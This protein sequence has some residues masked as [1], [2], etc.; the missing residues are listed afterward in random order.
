[1]DLG[2]STQRPQQKSNEFV[3]NAV[4]NTVLD[5][6]SEGLLK[7]FAEQEKVRANRVPGVRTVLVI[8]SSRGMVFDVDAIR[9]KVLLA[10]P[11]SA[12]FVQTT[13]GKAIGAEAPHS[14]DLL[15]DF[16]GPRQRQGLFA[17][18]RFRRMSRVAVGR[19]A[20]F[21]RAKIYDRVFDERKDGGGEL[22]RDL[23]ARERAVQKKVLE[24][25][26]VALARQGDTP[27]DRG[28]SIALELGRL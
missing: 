2:P 26:G 23:L 6:E 14:V 12:V 19:N 3:P 28:S 18:K 7:L 20:G 9:Q 21:F 4:P 24:L 13:R 27:P 11:D 16:T 10:Y 15:I 17:A 5:A 1:M 8:L 22:P 25:A